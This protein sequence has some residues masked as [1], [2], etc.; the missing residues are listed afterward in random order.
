MYGLHLL[1]GDLH[2]K[3]TCTKILFFFFTL[4]GLKILINSP[5]TQIIQY[6]THFKP[7]PDIKCLIHYPK[8]GI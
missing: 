5:E 6:L 3:S 2:Y 8:K 4:L 7:T 1:L